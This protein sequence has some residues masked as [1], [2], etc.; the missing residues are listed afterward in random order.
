[1]SSERQLKG[2]RRASLQNNGSLGVT[3]RLFLWQADA[4]SLCHISLFLSMYYLPFQHEPNCERTSDP[5][6]FTFLIS[7][8]EKLRHRELS[9]VSRPVLARQLYW[10]CLPWLLKRRDWC[11]VQSRF[12]LQLCVLMQ[13]NAGRGGW[14]S[15]YSEV[16]V[17]WL[18]FTASPTCAE[19]LPSYCF[20]RCDI[21]FKI[22]S[23]TGQI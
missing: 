4:P 10:P 6:W 3:R 12:G 7:Q 14:R 9:E 19:L 20:P 17:W 11:V 5:T 21:S 13:G 18:E 8:T 22:R 15:S 2:K 16:C 1:M 23:H